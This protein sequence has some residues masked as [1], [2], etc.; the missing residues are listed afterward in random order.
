[1]EN[2]F[3]NI[4]FKEIIIELWQWSSFSVT[5]C[6]FRENNSTKPQIIGAH[7][8]NRSSRQQR[9]TFISI[10]QQYG[11]MWHIG[12]YTMITVHVDSCIL[13][14]LGASR[15]SQ[16]YEAN[17]Q[18]SACRKISRGFAAKVWPMKAVYNNPQYDVLFCR[19]VYCTRSA[20]LPH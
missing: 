9:Q 12:T 6:A 10:Y 19:F 3:T 8:Y 20:H 16:T 17:R 15:Y 7:K 11:N 2:M 14:S 4:V 1:M 18:P 13:M 5:T